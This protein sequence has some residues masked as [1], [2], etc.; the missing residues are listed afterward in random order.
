MMRD[1]LYNY[2][3][4]VNGSAFFMGLLLQL[5]VH[6]VFDGFGELG[7]DKSEDLESLFWTCL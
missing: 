5:H 3:L 2:I 1:H 4:P 6:W 7:R